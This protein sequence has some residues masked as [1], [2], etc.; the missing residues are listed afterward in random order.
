MIVELLDGLE[1]EGQ[2]HGW[3]E[4]EFIEPDMA[5]GS[6]RLSAPMLGNNRGLL[7]DWLGGDLPGL[8]IRNPETDYR[9]VGFLTEY[10]V[11]DLGVDGFNVEAR[12]V[13]FSQL[14][15]D[16]TSWPDPSVNL[17]WAYQTTVFNDNLDDLSRAMIAEEIDPP[18]AEY[19]R[20]P[21]LMDIVPSTSSALPVEAV[22]ANMMPILGRLKEI[23]AGTGWFVQASYRLSTD[24][25]PVP[26]LR[27]EV[28]ER[29]L[30]TAVW[31]TRNENVGSISVTHRA[32]STTHFVG[33]GEETTAPQRVVAD[34]RNSDATWQR[35]YIEKLVNQPTLDAGA[36]QNEVDRQLAASGPVTVVTATDPDP[37]LWGQDLRVGWRAQL[38]VPNVDEDYE[39][40]ELPVAKS[41][42]KGS[43]G[44]WSRKIEFGALELR[45]VER[46]LF[47]VAKLRDATEL[48]MRG[49]K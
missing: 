37:G 43:A 25:V 19:R 16:R 29:P 6:W 32:A 17:A 1:V 14:L 11:D 46:L 28:I 24:A 5:V 21:W 47:N 12:G 18:S 49:L 13:T 35:R 23:L 33:V 26:S 45:D 8:A 9:D 10:T 36:L 40:M 7:R 15:V 3:A 31:S 34:A 48:A 20:P 30:S 22:A 44:D 42:L 27:F 41:T 39:Y 4:V 38:A 2:L